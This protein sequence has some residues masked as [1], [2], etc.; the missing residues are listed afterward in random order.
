MTDGD[1]GR[2]ESEAVPQDGSRRKFMVVGAGVVG[3]CVAGITIVPAASILTHPLRVPT[4]SGSDAFIPVGRLAQFKG[5]KPVKVDLYSDK[6][7]AWNRVVQVKV[8]S[9]WV[10]QRDGQLVAMSTVCPHLGCAIDYDAENDKFLCPCH[11]S[12]FSRA[13]EVETG[14]SPR[15]MDSLELQTEDEQVAIRYQRFKQGTEDKEPV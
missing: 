1:R 15:G 4:T 3:A 2:D 10:Q 5:D 9:A 7:D 12:Y 13:G 14:P 6:V 11:D 8:G